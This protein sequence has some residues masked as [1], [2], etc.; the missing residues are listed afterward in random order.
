MPFLD[1]DLPARLIAQQ[2]AAERDGSRLMH[3]P[4]GVSSPAHHQFREL[5]NLLFPDDLLGLNDTRVLPARLLG[6]RTS[7][8][9]KWEGLFLRQAD[10]GLWELMSQ[11]RG[12]LTAGETI[13]VGPGPLRLELV[14]RTPEGHWLA[15]P[16]TPGSAL[17]ALARHGHV[18]LPPYIRKGRAVAEDADR[19]QTVFAASPGA[20]AAPTAGLHFTTTIFEELAAR[21]IATTRLTLHVGPGTFQPIRTDDFRQ[22]AMHREWGE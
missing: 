22:H 6:H 16:N 5:P 14:E 13:E 3:L 19:Y 8:G 2:P 12:S 17:E 7:T 1:Y 18:P 21:A 20:I 10:D 9:C 15:R 4:P 11:T